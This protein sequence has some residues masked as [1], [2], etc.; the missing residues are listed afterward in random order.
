MF[1]SGKIKGII[2][3]NVAARGLDIPS[4]DLIIQIQPPDKPD[5]YIHRAGRTGRAGKT[6][7]C[8]TLFNSK[9]IHLME[10]I[11][12]EANIMFTNL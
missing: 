9:Q 2:A 1:K 6:G 12:R 7:K 4:V 8:V 10:K 11:E 5:D 3:T